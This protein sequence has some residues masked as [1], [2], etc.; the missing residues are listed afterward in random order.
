VA[1]SLLRLRSPL[2]ALG[3]RV[4]DDLPQVS[5]EIGEIPGVDAPRP[6][7]LRAGQGGAD[8]LRPGE[9]IVDVLPTGDEVPGAE[10]ARLLR[11]KR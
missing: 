5:V 8:G 3:V 11:S 2:R 9:Q 6:L 4:P 7:V 10:L 1:V